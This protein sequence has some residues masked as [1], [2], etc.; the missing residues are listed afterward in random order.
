MK[1]QLA[2]KNNAVHFE[3]SSES[4]TVKVNID[5]SEAIGGE[6]KGVRP[7]ELVLMA[8]GSC[9]VF[10]LSTILK[11][12]RQDVQDIHVEVAGD[13]REEIPN[14]FTKIH[15]SFSLKGDIDVEKAQK[16]AEL[17]VKKY[18]S[19][20]DMLAAGGVDITYSIKIN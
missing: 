7:M 18:C 5:G 16:A 19:V 2:R 10:D 8:L 11:K 3:A 14:I 20:H 9:S 15:I 1:V 4:S 17:A 12:Q 13:R 6:G